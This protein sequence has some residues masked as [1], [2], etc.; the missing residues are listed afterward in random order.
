[1]WL[2]QRMEAISEK[3]TGVT[4]PKLESRIM[5]AGRMEEMTQIPC[6]LLTD[7]DKKSRKGSEVKGKK[8]LSGRTIHSSC[9]LSLSCHFSLVF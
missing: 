8:P 2:R 1:V 9:F 3:N 7:K 4:K 6:F 5:Q